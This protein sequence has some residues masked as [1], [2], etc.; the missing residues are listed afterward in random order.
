MLK[1]T[2]LCEEIN[3]NQQVEAKKG[4]E[5]TLQKLQALKSR[6]S[7]LRAH[8]EELLKTHAEDEGS[9]RCDE[10]GGAIE[11]GQEVE[12]KNFS[13]KTHHYHKECFRKLWL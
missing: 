2:E 9:L 5:A 7:E 6:I 11:R 8:Y 12:A 1:K 4:I 13:E 3:S 10:C